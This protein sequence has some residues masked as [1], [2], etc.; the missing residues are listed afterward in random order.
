MG[1]IL[2]FS[3][4]I[5]VG[6]NFQIRKQISRGPL[7]EGSAQKNKKLSAVTDVGEKQQ[8]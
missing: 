1:N 5:T 6:V 7:E 2:I 4:I 3:L 8:W